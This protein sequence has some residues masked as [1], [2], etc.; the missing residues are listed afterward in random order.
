MPHHL[1]FS[2]NIASSWLRARAFHTLGVGFVAGVTWQLQSARL[3]SGSLMTCILALSVLGGM[4]FW[5]LETR[6]VKRHSLTSN[7]AFGV[8]LLLFLLAL[9]VGYVYTGLRALGVQKHQLAPELEGQ[10]LRL[11]GMVSSM[12]QPTDWGLR[13]DFRVQ[14][15]PPGVPDK[16][17]VHWNGGAQPEL[18]AETGHDERLTW[19]LGAR[20]ASL[21]P[22][23]EWQLSLRLKALH[24]QHNPG[25]FDGELWAWEQGL[26]ASASVVARE[27]AQLPVRLG[28][29]WTVPIERLR[30]GL[31]DRLLDYLQTESAPTSHPPARWAGVLAALLVGDQAA[32]GREDW[33]LFRT[34]GV[35]HLVS[36]SGLHITMFAW[37]ARRV[38]RTIWKRF[39]HWNVRW[40]APWVGAVG[41]WACAAFY[42]LLS[43]WGLPAQ[44]TVGMLAC[45]MGLRLGG[46]RWPWV[47]V[48]LAVL[49]GVVLVDPWALLSAGFWLSFVAVAVLFSSEAGT[50]A[51]VS[52]MPSQATAVPV[53]ESNYRWLGALFWGLL[54][55]QWVITLALAPLTLMLFQQQSLSGL[56]ANLFAVPWVTLVI[57]PLCML[58]V[59]VPSTWDVAG[60]A[61]HGLAIALQTVAQAPFASVNVAAAPLGLSVLGLLGAMV[62]VL[63]LPRTLRLLVCPPV[64]MVVLWQA[65]RPAAGQFE[66]NFTDI[67]QGNAV[68]V[69][70]LAHTLVYDSG[71]RYNSESDA[72][73]RILLPIL[74]RTAEPVHLLL[75]SHQ[76]ND[77]SGGADSLL[78]AFPGLAF[79]SSMPADHKAARSKTP[80]RCFDSA[81]GGQAWQWEG[82]SFEVLH[83]RQE[84]YAQTSPRPNALSC[85]LRISNGS[86]TVL[87]VGDLEAPQEERMVQEQAARL[88]ADVLLVPH[89]GSKTSSTGVFLDAVAPK[90]AV[91]QAGYRNRY[92]HPAPRILQRYVIR[93]IRVI[94][95][96]HCGAALWQSDQPA[97]IQ[98]SRQTDARYWHHQIP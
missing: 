56:V 42:A 48:W 50:S 45:V 57:T 41:G 15:P 12:V 27:A 14:N 13:F 66:V 96:P 30:Q 18:E 37:L 80:V 21:H 60:W 68:V 34:T 65:P 40:P 54:K 83:P 82:V 11:T 22:G 5:A 47:R 73:H 31:R 90:M 79:L 62:L 49:L 63:P 33:D 69:R 95:S 91:V 26:G 28:T 36:I 23:D 64:L 70:T 86:H 77:H 2:P 7:R 92:G 3:V 39:P 35:A 24:A 55:E 17:L 51:P 38:L 74:R 89:H 16:L 32:I 71:P 59:L 85:V 67:G 97:R 98:C 8:L 53:R 46:W 61:M 93:G 84:D 4:V 88:R 87:L 75:I 94:D 43:G 19:V 44:R 58:G 72:G 81:Q 1:T 76:D 29:H 20:P 9:Q 78:S 25:G 6:R 52:T 10:V